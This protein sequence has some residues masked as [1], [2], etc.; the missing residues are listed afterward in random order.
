MK[1][2]PKSTVRSM[3]SESDDLKK[4]PSKKRRGVLGKK[5]TTDGLNQQ[6]QRARQKKN[7]TT[8]PAPIVAPTKKVNLL[9]GET[10]KGVPSRAGPTAPRA[11]MTR[12]PAPKPNRS[13]AT[14][15]GMGICPR[16][17]VARNQLF[18]GQSPAGVGHESCIRLVIENGSRRRGESRQGAIFGTSIHAVRG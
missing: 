16:L 17:R 13:H 9:E 14:H 18:S 3:G 5:Y 1:L 8:P 15:V 7:R 2:R 6:A 4:S 12:R 10:S 11:Q